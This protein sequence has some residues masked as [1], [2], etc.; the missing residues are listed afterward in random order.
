MVVSLPNQLLAH[1]PITNISPEYTARLEASGDTSDE[2]EEDSEEEQDSEAEEGAKSTKG[3]GLPGLASLFSEGQWVS[4]VVVASKSQDS[5]IKL[6]GREG[7]ENVR[8]SRRIE[9]S[10]EPEK[11]NEGV[12]KGDLK[13]GFVR[14]NSLI[15][16]RTFADLLPLIDAHRL[17]EVC[18]GSRLH[19]L[20]RPPLPHLLLAVQRG[21]APAADTT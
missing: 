7:D 19:P 14:W 17:R 6:G 18:R 8:A 13:A 10:L 15:H 20:A 1:V 12:A 9:L 11:V 21:Q 5:K 16:R 2:E 4:A 3:P